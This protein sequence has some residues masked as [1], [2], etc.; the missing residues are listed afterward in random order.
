M[1]MMSC[2]FIASPGMAIL[3][4]IICRK[5]IATGYW[6]DG[7]GLIPDKGKDFSL[8]HNSQTAFGAQPASY[9]MGT[10]DCFPSGNAAGA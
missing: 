9:P 10:G 5:V 2:V 7:L 6:L 1:E 8:L 3:F 4:P